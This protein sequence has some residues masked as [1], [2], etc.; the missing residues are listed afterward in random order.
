MTARLNPYLSFKDNAREAMEFYRSVFGGKLDISTFKETPGAGDPSEG[1]KVMHAM[2]ET[3]NGLVIMA[4]DTPNRMEYREGSSISISL[5]GDDDAEL[6]DYYEKLKQGGAET[7]PMAKAPWGD[8]FGMVR[9]RYGID[10]LVNIS[11][12][13]SQA[14]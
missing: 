7:M 5:S 9:D 1:D 4:S 13:A 12:A 14:A 2:L 3:P 8:V 11:Q 6:R 10:W